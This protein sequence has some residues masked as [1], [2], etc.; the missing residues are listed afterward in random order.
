MEISDA[1]VVEVMQWL[2]VEFK[3]RRDC[4]TWQA[5]SS[6]RLLLQC[7]PVYSCQGLLVVAS[8]LHPFYCRIVNI[9]YKVKGY[10]SPKFK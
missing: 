6:F 1:K 2:V 4:L 10:F 5:L 7:I 3:L 8:P 9:Y